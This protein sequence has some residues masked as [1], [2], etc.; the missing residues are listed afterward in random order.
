[1]L[2]AR[3]NMMVLLDWLTE[4]AGVCDETI[5]V[6][7]IYALL[8]RPH[9]SSTDSNGA[10]FCIGVSITALHVN[11]MQAALSKLSLT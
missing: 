11:G 5:K 9:I 3:L 6:S 10:A 2:H 4:T 7:D 1:M 8:G